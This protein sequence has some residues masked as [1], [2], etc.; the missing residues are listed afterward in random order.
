MALR[1]GGPRPQGPRAVQLASPREVPE[2]VVALGP[3]AL[4]HRLRPPVAPLLAPV[5]PHRVASPVPDHRGRAETDLET[6]VADAPAEID[7]VARDTEPWIESAEGLEDVTA[8]GAVAAGDV[9]SL[10]IGQEHVIRVAGRV[11]DAPRRQ[12]RVGRRDVRAPD[13][14][15][16][17]LRQ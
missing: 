13:R 2:G 15:A 14:G 8:N 10:A 17:A 12:L 7:V 9:L 1:R 5:C 11:R 16:V 4:E 3:L 6:Q